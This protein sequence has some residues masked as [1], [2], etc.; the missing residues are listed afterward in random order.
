LSTMLYL[1]CWF[2]H[3]FIEENGVVYPAFDASSCGWIKFASGIRMPSIN[4]PRQFLHLRVCGRSRYSAKK[5]KEGN[6]RAMTFCVAD[7]HGQWLLFEYLMKKIEF[8]PR[9]DRLYVVGDGIDRGPGSGSIQLLQYFRDN[10]SVHLIR[11][12]HE[13][14]MLRTYGIGT[15]RL[16][17]HRWIE[18]GGRNTFYALQQLPSSERER[19]LAFVAASPDQ[20]TVEVNGQRFHLVHALP[21][22]DPYIRIWGRDESNAVFPKDALT[23]CGHTP[24]ATGEIYFDPHRRFVRI[25]CGMRRLAC[26]RLEDMETFY[27]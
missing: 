25:D 10:P 4:R 2:V 11:G 16:E 9:K 18:T 20:M 27:V 13:E 23:I 19:L 21:S 17:L 14:L 8:D 22:P 7:I 1:G 12:N 3:T 6:E 24:T 5:K 15:N 26:L